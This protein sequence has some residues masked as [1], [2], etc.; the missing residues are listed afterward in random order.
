MRLGGPARFVVEAETEEDV[1]EAY[2]FALEK[3]LPLYPLGSGANSLGLDDGFPGVILLNKIKGFRILEVSGSK[4]LVKAGG[5]EIWD[6]LVAF[7][8][9]KGFADLAVLSG[10]PGTVGAAPVQNI[11]AYGGEAKDT[12]TSVEVY[13]SLLDEFRELK[14]EDC[15]FSYR[16][17]IFN[18]GTTKGRYFILSATFEL[19]QKTLEPPFYNSLQKYLD[20]H[21]I[22]DYSPKNIRNAVSAIRKE[23]LP[24]PETTPSAGSFFKNLYAPASEKSRLESLG[25]SLRDAGNGTYKLNV[26][27]VLELAGLKGKI[28]H[29]FQVSEKAPLVLINVS[30]KTYHDLELA[31][32]E[33]SNLVKAKFGLTL[34]PEPVKISA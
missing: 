3:R 18:S 26:A 14:P 11:G 29:G 17:S 5:G 28:F 4:L 33:I 25:L 6:D 32:S 8:C 20:A 7:T 1:R 34:E 12:L 2:N 23:K 9:E 10:I 22:S 19:T 24:D 30:G 15:G 16:H 21:H 31:V 13:D 27:Q